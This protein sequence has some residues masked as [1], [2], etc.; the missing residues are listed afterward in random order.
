MELQDVGWTNIEGF[1]SLDDSQAI[2]I[3]PLVL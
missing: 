2:L 3:I 1:E